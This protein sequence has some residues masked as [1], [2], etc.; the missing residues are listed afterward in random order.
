MKTAI[1]ILGLLILPS[2]YASAQDDSK[3]TGKNK[4]IYLVVSHIDCK[5]CQGLGYL[6]TAMYDFNRQDNS[7][8]HT[9]R[10]AGSVGVR[11]A[12]IIC[13]YCGGTGKIEIR[14]Y[15]SKL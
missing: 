5:D 12:R 15:K 4:T 7:N 1:L 9:E 10:G 14:E 2:L 6:N 3:E 8:T 11:I 13:P